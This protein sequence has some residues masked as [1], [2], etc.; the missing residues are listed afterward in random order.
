MS[1][2]LSTLVAIGTV[3][4]STLS[5]S[6]SI[7]THNFV[8]TASGWR[9]GQS[10]SNRTVTI[11]AQY[12][13]ANATTSGTVW[14]VNHTGFATATVDGIGSFTLNAVT[15]TFTNSAGSYGN[16]MGF[17]PAGGD[18][19][20]FTIPVGT[21]M[22]AADVQSTLLYSQGSMYLTG[23]GYITATGGSGVRFVTGNLVPAPGAVALL[24]LA[25]LAG[26][27]RR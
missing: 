11:T 21:S 24:G 3:A 9:A 17:G 18:Y 22:S 16:A 20:A 10:F 7:V 15:R 4:A 13:T 14:S 27:R 6:A 26:R 12:N 25:G 5:A 1:I 23:G 19:F 2:R 8:F